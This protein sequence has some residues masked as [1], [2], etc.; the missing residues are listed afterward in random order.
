MR[1]KTPYAMVLCVRHGSWKWPG[2]FVV[3]SEFYLRLIL[4]L[5]VC[6]GSPCCFAQ[7]GSVATLPDSPSP[8]PAA[9]DQNF[10]A[11]LAQFYREDWHGT[12]PQGPTPPRRGL[13]SPLQSPPF[14]NSD[15][16]YGGSPVLGEPDTNSYPLMTAINQARSRTKVYGWIE[17][18]L[19]FSTAAHRN[20]P[21][22]NDAYSNRFEMNQ[23]VVYAERLPDSVERDH[24]VWGYHVLA[25]FGT[26]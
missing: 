25:F 3:R 13:P 4:L 14:P 12:A 18:T 22:A 15:W 24:V 20:D 7:N 6:V 23:F 19:N 21:E 26:V 2:A 11:R 17:P 16:S 10:F 1:Q 8:Q 5:L 9:Q